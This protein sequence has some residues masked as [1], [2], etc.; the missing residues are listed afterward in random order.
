MPNSSQS[1]VAG[2]ERNFTGESALYAFSLIIV[3]DK[4]QMYPD[5]HPL[6]TS[7]RPLTHELALNPQQISIDE[8]TSSVVTPAQDG[9][10]VEARGQVVK[11]I[12]IAGTTGFLPKHQG[13]VTLS[14]KVELNAPESGYVAF[15][16]L[17]NLFRRYFDAQRFGEQAL[18]VGIRMVFSNTKDVE[19]WVV[20]PVAFR[21]ERSVPRNRFTYNY[22]IIL[23]AL[24][25][26]TN[27]LG[28]PGATSWSQVAQMDLVPWLQQKDGGFQYDVNIIFSEWST[29]SFPASAEGLQNLKALAQF[30]TD[31]H[32]AVVSYDDPVT[33]VFK[34][35][36]SSFDMAI[37]AAE[38][39]LSIADATP[40][41]L[42]GEAF[43]AALHVVERCH[44]TKARAELFASTYGERKGDYLDRFRGTEDMRGTTVEDAPHNSL[45]VDY[46]PPASAG[47]PVN[48]RVEEIIEGETLQQLAQ[49]VLGNASSFGDIILANNLSAPF[50]SPSAAN[51]K[52]GTLA[53][54]DSVIIPIYASQRSAQGLSTPSLDE[55]APSPTASGTVTS[56]GTSTFS[57]VDGESWMKDIWKGCTV[58]ITGGLGS[59][60]TRII[61]T[62]NKFTFTVDEPWTTTPDT[63]STYKVFQNRLVDAAEELRR[64]YG[65]DLALTEDYDL[66]LS[67]GDLKLVSGMDNML[68]ALTIKS[69]TEQGTLPMHPQ[70]GLLPEMGRKVTK[71]TLVIAKLN[72][73]RSL[74]EDP[75]I[76]DVEKAQIEVDGDTYRLTLGLLLKYDAI[77][78]VFERKV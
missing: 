46:G 52:P 51:R 73:I 28:Y 3:D 10:L 55:T 48:F 78:Q 18:R 38:N 47:L 40:G 13:G 29:Y 37:A 49:R 39:I 34:L 57:D 42:G 8:P 23:K 27:T 24:Y 35:G 5:T 56:A 26:W 20:E 21:T 6:Y 1:R 58:E 44:E 62:N 68:Q 12:T 2:N 54:G 14:Q 69:L 15:H 77:N 7:L 45:G 65:A 53:P 63:T 17:R 59:G 22:T 71:D 16:N 64:Y 43:E 36:A 60:Q 61:T 32:D 9:V 11:D 25:P 4:E 70:F 72:V 31:F 33:Q 30:A 76:T 74:L 41:L 66:V 75:R 19:A 67:N 50:L